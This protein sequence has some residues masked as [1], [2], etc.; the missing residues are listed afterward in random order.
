MASKETA[1][2]DEVDKADNTD[3]TSPCTLKAT[4]KDVPVSSF[5]HPLQSLLGKHLY[6]P[7]KFFYKVRD[8]APPCPIS[9]AELFGRVVALPSEENDECFQIDWLGCERHGPYSD[10]PEVLRPYLCPLFT[11]RKYGTYIQELVHFTEEDH[12]QIIATGIVF[13]LRP[14][15][16]SSSSSCS[17]NFSLEIQSN[18]SKNSPALSSI[19]KVTSQL[20]L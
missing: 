2:A 19:P 11:E 1:Q 10:I 9:V 8:D 17:S 15:S 16:P 6:A 12:N 7:H 3:D 13:R 4:S 20:V 18:S 14:K 5:E